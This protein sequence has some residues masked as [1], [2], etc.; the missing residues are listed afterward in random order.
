MKGI[1]GDLLIRLGLDS[2]EFNS[3]VDSAKKKTNMFADGIKKL[4]GIMAGVFAIEAIKGFAQNIIK[5]GRETIK[6]E[7]ELSAAIKANGKEVASTM[8]DYNRFTKEMMKI[9]TVDDEAISGMLRLAETLQ[10]SAPKEAAKNAMALSKALG[11]DLNTAVKMAVMAQSDMYTMLARYVP[12]LREAGTATERTA[13]YNK[14]LA[15]GMAIMNDE[16]KSTL[17]IL[18]QNRIAWDNLKESIGKAFVESKLFSDSVKEWQQWLNIISSDKISTWQKIMA[19]FSG[20]YADYYDKLIKEGEANDKRRDSYIEYISSL[21]KVGEKKKEEILTED[22]LAKIKDAA[23]KRLE[24]ESDEYNNQIELLQKIDETK[25][26]A[27]SSITSKAVNP[28][29][30]KPATDANVQGEFGDIFSRFPLSAEK[31]EDLNFDTEAFQKKSK[32]FNQFKEDM[33]FAVADFGVNVVEEFGQSIGEMIASGNFDFSDFGKSILAGIG[34]F[35]SQLGKMMIQMG[36]A[37]GAFQKLLESSF[38]N[39]VA[40]GLLVAAGLGLVLLG[41]AIQ[42]AAK[43]GPNGASSSG[44]VSAPS[45]SRAGSPS[46]G[47]RAEDNKVVFEIKGDKLV[48]VLSNVQRKNLNMA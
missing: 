26:K 45:Y 36:I 2:K 42:G 9:S 38:M 19:S 48:G 27:I 12:A 17:G 15:S 10:S 7:N 24:K 28:E 22:E 6:I 14:L 5:L 21:D 44:S 23:I 3:G 40:P 16:A 46:S 1:L 13:E 4:G 43:A 18:E 29:D 41:G 30:L 37:A 11:V 39:P 31:E 47:Y 32:Q 20:N 34:G 33:A 8:A 35:I 25:R